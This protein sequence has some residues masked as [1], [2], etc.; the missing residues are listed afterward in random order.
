MCKLASA[1]SLAFIQID[2]VMSFFFTVHDF[3]I[4]TKLGRLLE[5]EVL[6]T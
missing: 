2:A 6:Y 5:G 4:E 3:T 1:L